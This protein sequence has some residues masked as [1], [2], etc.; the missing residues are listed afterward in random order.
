MSLRRLLAL[1]AVTTLVLATAAACS[2]DDDGDDAAT[3]T[4]R[5]SATTG[6]SGTSTP[7]GG[8]P[9]ELSG[10]VNDRGTGTV[11]ADNEIDVDTVDFAF[12]PTFIQAT[13]GQTVRIEI[14]NEGGAPHTF[15]SDAL[16]VDQEIGP[17]EDATVEVTVPQEGAVGFYCRFHRGQG[18]QGAIFTA[19][20]QSVTG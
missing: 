6:G 19:A 2:S 7:S 8:A 13:P 10:P 14:S 15:T 18:M 4:T 12:S 1:A 20:G 5:A 17:D 3:T 11:E 9:V 16:E